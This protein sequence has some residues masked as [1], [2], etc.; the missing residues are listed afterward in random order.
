[1][2]EAASCGT[3]IISDDWPGLKT[4]FQPNDEILIASE[5]RDVLEILQGMPEHVAREIGSRARERVL[6]EHTSAHRAL[7]FERYIRAARTYT[8]S[9]SDMGS[10]SPRREEAAVL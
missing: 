9:P 7:E 8:D 6:R 4:L 3:P 2:F 5:A 10:K 1:L